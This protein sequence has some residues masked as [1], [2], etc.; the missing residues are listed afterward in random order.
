VCGTLCLVV[1]Q[2]KCLYLMSH[3][4]SGYCDKSVQEKEIIRAVENAL[5]VVLRDVIICLH[6][7]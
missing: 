7:P 1:I 4:G 5:V 3:A 2:G 6:Y